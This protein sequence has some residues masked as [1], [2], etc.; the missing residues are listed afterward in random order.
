MEINVS[1]M[2]SVPLNGVDKEYAMEINKMAMYVKN[3]MI[4]KAWFALKIFVE[5]WSIQISLII[6][7]ISLD[8]M[9]IYVDF[10]KTVYLD[11]VLIIIAMEI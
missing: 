11:I 8:K 4:V 5:F 2:L 6:I 3:M 7:W 9:E 1:K 10:L